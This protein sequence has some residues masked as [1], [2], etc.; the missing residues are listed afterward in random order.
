MRKKIF[1]SIIAAGL[2]IASIMMLVTGILFQSVIQDVMQDNVRQVS[3]LIRQEVEQRLQD[4]EVLFPLHQELSNIRITLVNAD[5]VV[6]YD[7]EIDA[8]LLANHANRPEVQQAQEI[9][10]G[11][12]MRVSESLGGITYYYAW[13]L[14][15][16]QILRIAKEEISWIGV[17]R[18]YLPIG[19]GALIVVVL[20][21]F[22]ISSHLSHAIIQPLENIAASLNRGKVEVPYKE[23]LPFQSIILQQRL[24]INQQINELKKEQ[25][26]VTGMMNHMREGFFLLDRDHKILTINDAAIYLLEARQDTYFYKHV[27]ALTRNQELLALIQLVE[28]EGKAQTKIIDIGSK[29]IRFFINAIYEQKRL[30]G[31]MLFLL[32]VSEQQRMEKLRREFTSNVSHE[33]KT[34]LTSISGFAEMIHSDMIHS[35]EDAKYFAGKIQQEAKR[36]NY[37]VSDILKLSKIEESKNKEFEQVEMRKIVLTAMDHLQLIAQEKKVRLI[38]QCD[39]II[40]EGNL[41][42]LDELVYNLIDNAIRYNV[43]G[44]FVQVAAVST[45]TQLE[46]RVKD[47]GIGIKEKYRGRIFERFFTVDKSHSKTSSGTGLGLSIVKHIVEYH[48]GT[49]TVESMEGAGSEFIVSLPLVQPAAQ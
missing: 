14:S 10:F 6:A 49:I 13:E 12:S 7:N 42:L 41:H 20:F 40:V 25:D 9:G 46:L 15:N 21:G 5:G 31:I 43:E 47:S 28:A 11:Q 27:L 17:M 8:S 2:A 45:G 30:D 19:G 16:H 29:A 39:P 32:D 3:V 4:G 23:L 24:Q 18:G 44:G 36:M 35:M 1:F 37:L 33:L 38:E 22:Y 48:G 26:K 34:P